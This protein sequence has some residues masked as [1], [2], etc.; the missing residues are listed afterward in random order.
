MHVFTKR[1]MMRERVAA[2]NEAIYM[3]WLQQFEVK[4]VHNGNHRYMNL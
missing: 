2:G 4:L 3:C 1:Y